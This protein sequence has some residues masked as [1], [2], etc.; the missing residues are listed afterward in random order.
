MLMIWS[1]NKSNLFLIQMSFIFLI[2]HFS[3]DMISWR[4][5]MLDDSSISVSQSSHSIVVFFSCVRG[6]ISFF[7]IHF[8]Y[9]LI[10]Y[11]YFVIETTFLLTQLNKHLTWVIKY[12]NVY[13]WGH[14]FSIKS[15]LQTE[16]T[17]PILTWWPVFE[18]TV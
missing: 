18:I 12:S 3:D 4:A 10:L 7:W 15:I 1:Y 16:Y 8:C 13:T 11:H 17:T 6:I 9:S 14:M 5:R 2:H